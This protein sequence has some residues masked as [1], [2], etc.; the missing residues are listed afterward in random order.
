MRSRRFVAVRSWD[1]GL[2]EHLGELIEDVERRREVEV[3]L[4][5]EIPVDR[6]LAD[7]GV[8]GDLVD[9]HAVEGLRG[10]DFRRGIQDGAF[11]GF[12][13]DSGHDF[14]PIPELTSQF[15]ITYESRPA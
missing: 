3:V 15:C 7:P 9:E 13:L 6:S 11:F 12:G 1:Q 2:G 14:L 8:G 5:L 4:G 10:E